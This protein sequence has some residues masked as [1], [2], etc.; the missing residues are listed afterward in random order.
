M[1]IQDSVG[2]Q[3]VVDRVRF[4]REVVGGGEGGGLEP[5]GRR[6]SLSLEEHGCSVVTGRQEQWLGAG[7]CY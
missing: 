4:L 6:T 1:D 3:R 5:K 2:E 7:G